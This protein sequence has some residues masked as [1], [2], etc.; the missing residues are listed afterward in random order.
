MPFYT[1]KITLYRKQWKTDDI[2]AYMESDD[3]K[4]LNETVHGKAE[5]KTKIKF[6]W[7]PIRLR[8]KNFLWLK[9]YVERTLEYLNVR[10]RERLTMQEYTILKI[11]GTHENI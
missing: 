8:N 6:A 1:E 3:Y 4:T 11:K 2:I 10:G 9:N 7:L 5:I